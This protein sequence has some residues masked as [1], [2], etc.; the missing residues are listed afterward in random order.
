MAITYVTRKCRCGATF[1][2][3]PADVKR[4][5]AKSC[6]KSCAA[7]KRESRTGA[8]AAHVANGGRSGDRP[9]GRFM[10]ERRRERDHESAMYDMDSGWDGHKDAF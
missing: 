7:N 2:A 10:M 6:S 5:W 3:R 1:Q 4:G 9:D 8:F